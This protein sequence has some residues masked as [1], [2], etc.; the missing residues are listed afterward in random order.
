MIM[1]V[2]CYH[3]DHITV[4][5]YVKLQF[6]NSFRM[7]FQF[8]AISVLYDPTNKLFAGDDSLFNDIVPK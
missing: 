4:Y 8:N 3:G 7:Y 5:S 6:Y 1:N 2:E